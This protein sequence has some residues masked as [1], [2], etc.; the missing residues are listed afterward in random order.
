MATDINPVLQF[1]A[2][3][4]ADQLNAGQLQASNVGDAEQQGHIAEQKLQEAAALTKIVDNQKLTALMKAQDDT[5]I[6]KSAFGGT[7]GDPNELIGQ[8]AQTFRENTIVANE[9]AKKIQQM[10]SVS[11]SDNPL[12]WLQNQF[13]INGEIDKHNTATAAAEQASSAMQTIS[14][15]T[16]SAAASNLAAA[17][18]LSQESVAAA[19]D[20][21][22]LTAGAKLAELKQQNLRANSADIKALQD[23]QQQVLSN[24]FQ[25]VHLQ[26]SAGAERRAEEEHALQMQ[27]LAASLKAKEATLETD[28]NALDTLNAGMAAHG[29]P[30]IATMKEFKAVMSNPDI[31]AKI[32]PIWRAGMNRV[33][34]GRLFIGADPADAILNI[35]KVKSDW[36]NN[37]ARSTV[38]YLDGLYQK[39]V[40]SV[41]GITNAKDREAQLVNTINTLAAK[42][43][44]HWQNNA[45]SPDSIYQAPDLES[46]TTMSP[47]LQ[48]TKLYGAVLK[49]LIDAGAKSIT[50][51]GIHDAT[52]AAI[53]SGAIHSKVAFDEVPK[54]FQAVANYNSTYRNYDAMGIPPQTTYSIVHKSNIPFFGSDR[55]FDLTKREQFLHYSM[56]KQALK[57]ATAGSLFNVNPFNVN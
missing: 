17:K 22:L 5:N 31:K 56:Y 25:G 39:A 6:I 52:M 32:E 48:K 46:L 44:K 30:P 20:E 29:F 45:E 13:T 55:K 19:L 23:G 26:M 15:V 24:M 51:E 35:K 57:Q 2:Q 16:S 50:G 12:A 41:Q 11:F 28:Q 49:P 8:L 4:N 33:T 18:T 47:D 14:A 3:R 38:E 40:A 43:V 54:L 53:R 1:L 34:T 27:A 21:H 10:D 7:I 42:D 36:S 37:P 9:Q